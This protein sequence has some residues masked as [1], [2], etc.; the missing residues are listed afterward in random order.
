E[1][2]ADKDGI[3]VFELSH[4]ANNNLE[5][6]ASAILKDRQAFSTGNSYSNARQDEQWRIYAFTDRPA[7]RPK[8]TVQWKFIA[9]RYNGS[10]YS[11]PSEQKIEFRIDDA[12]GAKV[13]EDK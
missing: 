8:E 10:V 4:P 7:Y 6:F 13:K 11:T 3:A 2:T 12:R 5:L 1:K 9:R